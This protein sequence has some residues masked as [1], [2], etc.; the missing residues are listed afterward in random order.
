MKNRIEI[1]KG[2]INNIIQ[3]KNNS[4]AHREIYAHLYGVSNFC[5]LIALKRNL[6]AELATMAGL[7]HDLHTY[8][9]L[10]SKG[11]AKKGAVLAKET[12][13]ALKITSD[14]ETDLIRKAISEHNDKENKHDDFTEILIDADVMQHYLQNISLPVMEKENQRLQ[15]LK[16]EFLF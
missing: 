4:I 6:N 2:Y 10:N 3:H 14:E 15:K 7:L 11:H 9:H 16:E 5:A 13:D 8:I 1:L 12:L